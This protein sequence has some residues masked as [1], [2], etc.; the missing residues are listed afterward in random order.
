MI[1]LTREWARLAPFPE[2]A[3]NLE[4]STAGGMFT[5]AFRASFQTSP[6]II[7][8]WLSDSPGT[9]EIEPDRS[10][11]GVRRYRIHP[12]GGAQHAEVTVDD[13]SHV[14]RIYVDWS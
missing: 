10:D 4:V 14:V 12:G 5:R 3:S 13:N 9:K 11:S 6:P 7:E 2:G 1:R 8:K